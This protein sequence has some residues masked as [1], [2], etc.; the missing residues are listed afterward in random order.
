M[1]DIGNGEGGRPCGDFRLQ[2]G[3]ADSNRRKEADDRPVKPTENR[4]KQCVRVIP[5]CINKRHVRLEEY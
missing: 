2:N 4:G 1:D 5:L 3:L